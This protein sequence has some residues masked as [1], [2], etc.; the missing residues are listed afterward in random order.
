MKKFLF[1]ALL[2]ITTTAV[3][4]AQTPYTVSKDEKHPEVTVLNGIITKYA[5]QN[6]T[7]FNKWYTEN[8]G[9]YTP[10]NEIVNAMEASKGKVQFV[11]FG[12]TWCEDT[13]F[14]LPKFFKLQQQAGFPDSAI[15][16]FAVTRAKQTI[17]NITSAFKITNVPTIIVMKDGKEIGR[18]VEYGTT[19]K[20]DAELAELLK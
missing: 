8:Q 20:W 6:N 13:Q 15:S 18:V 4:H 7:E 5:L 9:Y 16:F 2:I 3:L 14:V 10:A 11:L 17:G 1:T 12:G 19:G